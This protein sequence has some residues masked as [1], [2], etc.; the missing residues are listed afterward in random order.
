MRLG[1][2]VIPCF[3]GLLCYSSRDNQA[4]I[5]EKKDSMVREQHAR[6]TL[7]LSL[8]LSLSCVHGYRLGYVLRSSLG[9]VCR[10]MRG[11]SSFDGGHGSRA[12]LL[13]YVAHQPV[14]PGRPETT[15]IYISPL[16]MKLD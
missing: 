10:P 6:G 11:Y 16:N 4:E 14:A 5:H 1:E 2:C 3:F 9:H 13:L 12:W 7:S 8:S 15:S